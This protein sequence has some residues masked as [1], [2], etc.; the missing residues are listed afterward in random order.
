MHRMFAVCALL[1]GFC[2]TALSQPSGWQL[3]EGLRPHRLRVEDGRV[4][5]VMLY[6]PRDF[7]GKALPLILFLHG[8]GERGDDPQMLVRWP[9]LSYLVGRSDFPFIVAAPQLPAGEVWNSGHVLPVLDALLSQSL[10][11]DR[12]RVSLTGLSMGGEATWQ[13][14][15]AAP[16]RF[17]A[18]VPIASKGELTEPCRL[19]RTPIWSFHNEADKLAPVEG[20]QKVVKQLADCGNAA[21]LTIYPRAG[22][23]AWSA[24]YATAELFDWLSRQS[25]P[26]TT[27][28]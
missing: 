6:L 5:N 4:F 7:A 15:L 18:L 27:S 28:R 16:G 23:N 10:P 12:S 3:E 26:G 1:L 14:G 25:L 20:V 22:H 17:A 19:G 21:R 2:Q 9:L 11:L 8:A 13:A 24:A